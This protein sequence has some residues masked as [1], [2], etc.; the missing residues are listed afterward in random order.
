[1]L[2]CLADAADRDQET[3]AIEV[4]KEETGATE[5]DQEARSW[6]ATLK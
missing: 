1:M 6:Q 2:I 3:D 5:A 4:V